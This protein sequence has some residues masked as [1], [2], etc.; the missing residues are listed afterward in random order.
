MVSSVKG[1]LRVG[2]AFC[3]L[4]LVLPITSAEDIGPIPQNDAGSGRDAPDMISDEVTIFPGIVYE[5]STY[6][7]IGDIEDYYHLT[8]EAG[9]RLEARTS[10]NLGCYYLLDKEGNQVGD[11][12]CSYTHVPLDVGAV[13]AVLPYTGDYYLRVAHLAP[14][15][16]HFAYNLSGPVPEVRALA[17]A[18]GQ[19]GA[20]EPA[21][22]L[23]IPEGCHG[24]FGHVSGLIGPIPRF[25]DDCYHMRTGLNGLDTPE[26]DVLIIPPVSTYP[27]RDLRTMR[28]AVEMW[29]DGIH[30]L[31]TE[32]DMQWLSDGVDIEIFI[33]DDRLSTDPLWDPE[34]VVVATNPVG[35]AGIGID[36]L[37][38]VFGIKG[39]CHG[40]PNP[41]AGFEDWAAIPGFDNHHGNESGTYTADCE[42]G[43]PICYAINGAIDPAPGF[44]DFFGLFD[45]VAH[46]V[47]HCLTV[48]HVG[49]ANDHEAEA[50]PYADI[51]SYTDQPHD[52]C[53][54][55]LDVQAFALTMSR[56][57]L[58]VPIGANHA[59]GPGGSFHIQHPDDHWYASPSGLAKDCVP[60]DVSI[61]PGGGPEVLPGQDDAGSGGDAPNAFVKDIT[62]LPD[63]VYEGS[64]TGILT[65]DRDIYH[66]EGT[67]GQTFTGWVDGSVGCYA[68][69]TDQGEN[70]KGACNRPG[71]IQLDSGAAVIVLP[72]TGDYYFR[73][74]HT[75]PSSYTFAYN[76][77][78]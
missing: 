51:M 1:P 24:E 26:I 20:P 13:V 44:I 38:M 9:Q 71:G 75:T 16:Y 60:R 21:Q 63:T 64:S 74:G 37:A 56:Y 58:D 45:L 15:V 14:A 48:G 47:G 27:E 68:L 10:G 33:D 73:I 4:L 3:V 69:H 42:G 66:L 53:V 36:P 46:E 40:Q 12:S 35:G 22:P 49:D 5:G 67:A 50:V 41:L 28:A 55:T 31:A 17:H 65:D 19:E 39:P 57:L 62:I 70:M 43:G 76:L 11:Y 32:M 77:T 7:P 25:T 59:E 34:I 61:V 29:D 78:A 72:Y 2:V 52:K 23:P 8:G 30:T 6:G 18:L 54:S